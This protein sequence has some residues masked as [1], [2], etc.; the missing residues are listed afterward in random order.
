MR[1]RRQQQDDFSR[2]IS[3]AFDGRLLPLPNVPKGVR[4]RGGGAGPSS[5]LKSSLDEGRGLHLSVVV[6]GLSRV[7]QQVRHALY[8]LEDDDDCYDI[9]VGTL[10]DSSVVSGVLKCQVGVESKL[11]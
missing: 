10:D 5:R 6:C 7:L 2:G 1:T 8:M 11:S 4:E 3:A 9:A